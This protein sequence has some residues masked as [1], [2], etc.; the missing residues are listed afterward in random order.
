MVLIDSFGRPLLNLRI[1]ITSRC[2]LRCNYC[3][4]EGEEEYLA[5]TTKEMTAGEIV[6][7][8]KVAVSL[9]ISRIKITGG[10]PL[11]R[12]DLPQIIKEIS[13]IENVR[14]LSMTTNGTLLSFTAQQLYSNGLK[15]V[16]IG[17]PSLDAET[18]NK[19]TDGKVEDALKGIRAAVKT[20]FQPVKLN[21]VILNNINAQAVS[22][23]ID[24]AGQNGVI[25]QLI[26]LDPIN[27]KKEY[28]AIH[29]K[30]M[31]EYE[32]ALKDKALK[33]ETRRFMHNRHIYHLPKAT[34][35]VV[36]PIEN[37]EFCTHC[38]RLRITSDGKL[39]PCLMRNDNTVNLL[40]ALRNGENDEELR[41][42]FKTANQRRKPYNITA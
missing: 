22:E 17:L 8:A 11:M 29:H 40:A 31:D 23:M 41:T 35:E 27:V 14:D 1:S 13:S 5:E 36:R 6:R 32:E 28:Y 7:I 37:T 38:T 15:R 34:V 3:H 2:N 26:E 16:N 25:L 18:Y 21:I 33:V 42:I 24:F 20:G 39:K 12:K 30:S 4:K 19:L 10:E 9:G